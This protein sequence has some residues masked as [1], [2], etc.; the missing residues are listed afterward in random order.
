MSKTRKWYARPVYALFALVLVLSF[1]LVA[2]PVVANGDP[3][4]TIASSTMIFEGSLTAAG[5][6]VYTGTISMVNEQAEG[7]GDGIAGFDVYA[8]DGGCAYVEGYYGTGEWNCDGPDTYLI[9]SG[10]DAYGEA[11]PWG[12][13]YD[14][15]CAD[16]DQYSLELTADH[17]YLRYTATGESPM[18]GVMYWYGDGTGYAAETDPGTVR[19]DDGTNPTDPLNRDATRYASGSAQEWGW[20]CGWGEERIPLELPGFAVQVTPGGSYIV[21]LTPDEGPVLNVDTSVT[22]GTI[23]LAVADAGAGHTIQVAAGTYTEGPGIVISN[24]LTI[25]GA[26]SATTI[27][28]PSADTAL[29]GAMFEVN[30]DVTFHISDVTLDGT[31][32]KVWYALQYKGGGSVT[33]CDFKHIQYNPSGPNYNG[34]AIGAYGE[35]YDDTIDF[36]DNVDITGCT[37]T[38]IGRI[39]VLYFGPGITNSTYSGNTYVGKGDGDWLDY[40]LDVGSGPNVTIT[41]STISDCT[42]VASSDNSTSCGI[43]VTDYWKGWCPAYISTEATITENNIFGCTAGI[44]VGYDDTDASVVVAHYNNLV[45]NDYGVDSTAPL[46]DATYNWWGSSSGPYHA[47][48]NPAGTGDAVSDYVDFEPWLLEVPTVTTQA[49]TGVGLLK[50]T[51]NMNYTVGGYSPV[52]IRFAYKESAN[53]AWSYTAWVSKAGHGTHATLFDWRQLAPNTEYDFKAQLKYND[54]VIEGATLQ[55]TTDTITPCFIA[56]AAYGTP[57]AEQIDVLREFRDLVLVENSVGS[58][59][60]DLYYQVSP[61]IADFIAGNDLLRTVVRELLVDPIVWMVEATRDMWRN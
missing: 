17:W 51:L 57:T 9:V 36:D 54:T 18:S 55:F 23:Q 5:G 59:F 20:H 16:W 41:G 48:L 2:V 40:A 6:G 60:V 4:S 61:P 35:A 38:G 43:M 26:D 49:A 27:I 33:D 10:H 15:D 39:G 45:G 28:K 22:Y 56:T 50:A 14:P 30:P 31:G 46:V 24:N 12:G 11:G 32:K 19:N 1:S 21:T 34:I 47:T 44:G 8:E 7:L 53:T 37:F 25:I 42:G 58:Q 3:P 29:Y 13:W 52:Q